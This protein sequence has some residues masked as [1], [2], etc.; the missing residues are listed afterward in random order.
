MRNAIFAAGLG[1][2]GLLL[3]GCAPGPGPAKAEIRQGYD[4]L[5]RQDYDGALAAAD[6]FLQH[7]PKGA[8]SAEAYY[9]KGR[10]YEQRAQEPGHDPATAK[11]DLDAARSAY[12][13][14]LTVPAAPKVLALLHA[15]L[16]NIAYH[17]DDYGTA[18]REWQVSYN[19][20]EPLEAKA[21]VLYRI[22]VCQQRL[23]W[24]PQADR[25]F[26]MVR[27][28]FP[29]SEPA[30]RAA[31][32][33]GATGFYVQV[34]AYTDFANANRTVSSLKTQG[35]N[36]EVVARPTEEIVRVGPLPNFAEARSLQIRLIGSY[37]G[38]IVVP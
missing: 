6:K 1:L 30:Q 38:S 18:V 26:G 29:A 13:S 25:S 15:G 22:G 32:H 28:N 35:L 31:Q 5:D 36:A 21:W 16:A 3:V 9:L 10:V 14:G 20:I 12:T 11:G 24:F 23:G 8:G 2:A 4:A 33:E 34:G 19:A 27:A 37:P 17:F 7:T